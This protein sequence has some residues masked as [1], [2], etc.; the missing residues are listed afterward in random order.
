[1]NSLNKQGLFFLVIAAIVALIFA[2]VAIPENRKSAFTAKAKKPLTKYE[3]PMYFRLVE[4]FPE[5]V[6]LAQVSFS[7]LMSSNTTSSR[8]RFDRKTADFVLCT[9]S[10]DVVAVIE[11]DDASHNGKTKSDSD[12]D[13]LLKGVGYHVLRFK[14]TPDIA[15]VQTAV[16]SIGKA[17]V[18]PSNKTMRTGFHSENEVL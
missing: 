6:V 4:S 18:S 17:V 13:A 10:F 11:L 1:M 3:Q 7:A 5:L 12:R 15:V 14:K 16:A 9:K 2:V 8:N